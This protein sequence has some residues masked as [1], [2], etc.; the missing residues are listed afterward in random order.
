M[1]YLFGTN[2]GGDGAVQVWDVRFDREFDGPVT[3]SFG[4]DDALLTPYWQAHED[5]LGIWHYGQYGP[6][7]AQQWQ[8]L[9]DAVDIDNNILTVT[10]DNFSPMVLGS[11]VTAPPGT[12]PEPMTMLA[13]G[14]GITGLGGYIRKRRR[15]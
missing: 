6:A 12:I 14:L 10:V 1:F 4:Y 11:N 8:F 3:L 13:V 15:G 2:Y 9:Q 5:E 7:G